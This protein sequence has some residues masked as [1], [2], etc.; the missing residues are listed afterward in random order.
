MG[1]RFR[2]GALTLGASKGSSTGRRLAIGGRR[3]VMCEIS[4][5]KK[6]PRSVAGL[7]GYLGGEGY[8]LPI[9]VFLGEHLP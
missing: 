6:K 3:V 4:Y 1:F 2:R 7:R 8:G 5:G 9:A